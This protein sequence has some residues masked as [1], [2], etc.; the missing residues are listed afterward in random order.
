[1][2]SL[3]DKAADLVR[4]AVA[5]TAEPGERANAALAAC[6]MIDRHR[7]LEAGAGAESRANSS[8][9]AA[10]R[11]RV[12]SVRVILDSAS[13]CRTCMQRIPAGA[14]RHHIETRGYQCDECGPW[15]A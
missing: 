13:L 7:L 8:A 1:M 9:H 3:R 6:R 11:T 4:L 5:P 12:S 10:P 15:T 2:K 14:P